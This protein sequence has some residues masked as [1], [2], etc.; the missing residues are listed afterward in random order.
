M[1]IRYDEMKI[2][3]IARRLGV[4]ETTVLAYL[5]CNTPRLWAT[6]EG[7]SVRRYVGT[8][9]RLRRSLRHLRS[10]PRKRA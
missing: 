7:T 4:C 2:K 3:E 8:T 5:R 6:R 1:S 10:E 9:V